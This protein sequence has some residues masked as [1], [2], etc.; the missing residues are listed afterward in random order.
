MAS[1]LAFENK[2]MDKHAGMFFDNCG[3]LDV[4]VALSVEILCFCVI[5]SCF[6]VACDK[7]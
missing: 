1:W 4:G 5:L 3:L 7:V 2:N 6:S